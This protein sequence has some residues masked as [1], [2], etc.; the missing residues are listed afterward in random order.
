MTALKSARTNTATAGVRIGAAVGVLCVVQ[1][2]VKGQRVVK[3]QHRCRF[4]SG[5]ALVEEKTCTGQEETCL[6]Q[7]VQSTNTCIVGNTPNSHQ[8]F[9]VY[10]IH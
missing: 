2:Q 5:R 1:I 4:D 8:F 10:V 7:R 6:Q 9:Y 3:T